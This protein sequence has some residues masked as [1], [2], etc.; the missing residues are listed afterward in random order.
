MAE[1]LKTDSEIIKSLDSTPVRSVVTGFGL[2]KKLS[3]IF[4]AGEVAKPDNE[5]P[6]SSCSG[7]SGF[8]T[9]SSKEEDPEICLSNSVLELASPSWPVQESLMFRWV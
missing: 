2:S 8:G 5:S 7:D 6:N 3:S 4:G 1:S 9:N